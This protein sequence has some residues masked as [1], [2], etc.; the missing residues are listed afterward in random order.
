MLNTE[1]AKITQLFG[2]AFFLIHTFS[3]PEWKYSHNIQL[4]LFI[5]PSIR[6]LGL[7]RSAMRLSRVFQTSLHP[8]T[9]SSFLSSRGEPKAFPGLTRCLLPVGA[10]WKT[11]KGRHPRGILI[12]CS[13]HLSWLLWHRSGS[14]LSYP[15][16]NWGWSQPLY[17]KLF[18]LYPQSHSFWLISKAHDHRSLFATVVRYKVCISADVAPIWQSI[19]PPFYTYS[20]KR[21]TWTPLFVWCNNSL[22]TTVFCQRTTSS[23]LEVMTFIPVASWSAEIIS[24][25]ISPNSFHTLFISVSTSSGDP[26]ANQA[27]KASNS[28][29][30]DV[31][32]ST[33]TPGFHVTSKID[34][35]WSVWKNPRLEL[36]FTS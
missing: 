31:S 12:R 5:H 21:H 35:G 6:Y 28:G 29:I 27:Q 3:F 34:V 8:A 23:I 11:Y 19:S 30:C 20:W 24:P 7:S 33:V 18:H 4:I 25:I 17:R 14:T 10:A 15:T 36:I 13:D 16:Y 1:V 32:C 9:F 26:W 22:Q 2:F